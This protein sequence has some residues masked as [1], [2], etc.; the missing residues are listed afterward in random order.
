MS[1][2]NVHVR[3]FMR[4]HTKFLKLEENYKM[5]KGFDS[6]LLLSASDLHNHM[7]STVLPLKSHLFLF[8]WKCL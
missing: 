4:A 3:V 2:M 1:A 6:F 8:Q 5:K 7:T